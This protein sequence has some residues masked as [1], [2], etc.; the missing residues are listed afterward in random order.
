MKSFFFNRTVGF[1]MLVV[2]LA[3]CQKEITRPEL[4]SD[5]LSAARGGEG[6]GSCKLTTY[7]L[8]F[9]NGIF[10]QLD[11]YTYE[12]G[13]LKDW[14]VFYGGYYRMEYHTNGRMKRASYYFDDALVNTIDFVYEGNRVVLEIWRDAL[15]DE[16]IDEVTNTYNQRGLIVKSVSPGYDYEVLYDYDQ[17]GNVTRWRLIVGGSIQQQGEYTYEKP[18]RNP[19]RTIDGLAY[20]FGYSNGAAFSGPDWYTSERITL[21]DGNGDPSVFFDL[22]PGETAFISRPGNLPSQGTYT[23]ILTQLPYVINFE[24]NACGN[25]VNQKK[26]RSNPGKN[27]AG[28]RQLL[29]KHLGY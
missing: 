23:D 12:G 13:K 20:Q 22:D 19:I 1:C 7:D 11:E 2:T 25:D 26:A 4:R 24:F 17:K 21:F 28:Q 6:S 18:I 5:E 10:S 15:T 29:K 8:N 27:A 16:V 9:G 3:A 14:L